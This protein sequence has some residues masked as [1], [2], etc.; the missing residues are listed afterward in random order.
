MESVVAISSLAHI[1]FLSS[2]HNEAQHGNPNAPKESQQVDM[3]R[4]ASRL[5]RIASR[6]VA[7]EL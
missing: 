1:A 6:G 4:E 3:Y 5:S 7:G 2:L